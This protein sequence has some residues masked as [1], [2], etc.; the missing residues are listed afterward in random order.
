[1]SISTVLDV[2]LAGCSA[3][4]EEL[5]ALAGE[6]EG[7]G[8]VVAA[9]R[10]TE[11]DG[12]AGDAYRSR[13]A[14]VV[15]H[16]DSAAAW[17]ESSASAIEAFGDAA[18]C[19]RATIDDARDAA[20]AA[21]LTVTASAV[22]PPATA[23]ATVEVQLVGGPAVA[24]LLEAAH[25]ITRVE[26]DRARGDLEVAREELV[27]ALRSAEQARLPSVGELLPDGGTSITA[28][29]VRSD[30]FGAFVLQPSQE[31]LAR[32]RQFP[33]L[34]PRADAP[35]ISI[36]PQPAVATELGIPLVQHRSGLFLPQ[37][38]TG[39]PEVLKIKEASHG[40]TFHRLDRPTLVTDPTLGRPP[41]WARVGGGTLGVAGASLTIYDAYAGQWEEDHLDHP[42][43]TE[44]QRVT[45]ATATAAIEG[46]SAVAGA[47]AGA[48]LGAAAGSFI[49]IPVV[50]TVGGA[51]IGGAIGAFVAG[52]LGAEAAAQGREAIVGPRP[53]R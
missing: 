31:V 37:G 21:G 46:G 38:S 36:T 39:D 34:V 6:L 48:K 50:G 8:T 33:L 44:G 32:Y 3:A 13:M 28:G 47:W 18:R 40:P 16:L 22:L 52:R 30:V 14:T 15:T 5:H 49:P 23:P 53:P 24:A 51:L 4:A 43:W 12:D 2:D 26:V 42:G 27:E 1:M 9:A 20:A 41:T 45:S 10:Q 11:W 35:M 29:V 17:C 25:A 7:A 19:A